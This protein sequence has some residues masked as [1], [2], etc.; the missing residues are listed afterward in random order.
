MKFS[1]KSTVLFIGIIVSSVCVWLFARNIDW[2]I[3]LVSLKEANYIYVIPT[4]FIT[5]FVFVL[6]GLRWKSILSPVKNVPVI[7]LISASYIGF[8]ANNI[9]PARAGEIIRPVLASKKEKIK[10]TSSV[11]TV[12]L[13]RIF[14]MLGVLVFTVTV[15]ILIPTQNND[16][17]NH[18][19]TSNLTLEAHASPAQLNT[20]DNT[21]AKTKDS[22]LDLLK[23]WIGIFAGAGISALVF[24][25]LFIFIPTKMTKL[26]YAIFSIFPGKI[27]AR[28][29]ESLDPFIAGLQILGNKSH[30][31]WIF[32][33][34]ITIWTFI[35]LG[36]Y[37]LSFAFNLNLPF[38]GA[39]LVSICIAFAI[40]LPQAPGYI[41]VF[42]IATQKSLD[43]FNIELAS[44]QSY[45][46]TLWV[47][48]T[49]PTIIIGLIFLWKEGISFT[50]LTKFKN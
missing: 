40:A 19:Q 29:S 41:G 31:A 30:V 28:L 16:N 11:T 25:S 49:I 6:R 10:L 27:K 13:E 45:A 37:V 42:H 43:I 1:K 46:I 17:D 22:F 21:N 2:T 34:T 50:E 48:S 26:L 44:S 18:K 32:F 15:L 23:K 3:L 33:L 20:K 36:I 39:C 38:L 35:A 8:M 47:L 24:L 14:D 7:N 12:I 4:I 9:L 5:M